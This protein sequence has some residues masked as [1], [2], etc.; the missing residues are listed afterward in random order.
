MRRPFRPRSIALAALCLGVLPACDGKPPAAKLSPSPSPAAAKNPA[1]TPISPP[2]ATPKPVVTPTASPAPSSPPVLVPA[3]A[4]PT[5]S[6]KPRPTPDSARAA[7]PRAPASNDWHVVSMEG[8]RYVPVADVAAFYRMGI[9]ASDARSFRL[10]GPNRVIVGRAGASEVLINGVKYVTCFPTRTRGSTVYLSA[11]D[12]TKI[13]EPIMRPGKIK[14]AQPIRAVVLDAGHGGHDSG[15]VGRY[16]REKDFTLDVVLRTRALLLKAG[17]QVKTTRVS[18]VFIPLED[19]A[20]Y[21]RGFP[22]A[23]FVSVHFNKSNASPT[24]T[25]IETYALAPRGVPSMDEGSLRYSDF[26]E[27]PGNVNDARN[28]AL[29]A[30]IHSMLMRNVPLPDRGIKRARFLVLKNNHVPAVLVEGG[31][32][33]NARDARYIASV[34]YRQRLAL[35]IAQAVTA[36]AR[37]VNGTGTPSAVVTVNPPEPGTTPAP[38][39]EDTFGPAAAGEGEKKAAPTATPWKVDRLGTEP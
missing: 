5:A 32:V 4:S 16:G 39:S 7:E 30:A 36:Y 22:G 12:V 8:R 26:R 18:D 28:V 37:T 31:F 14:G 27:N 2:P 19:R 29:A 15:A 35:S 21:G 3:K 9:A 23:V 33:D 6:P 38:L 20:A 11:M 34:D 10:T 17:F 13:V 1:P 25:G 24:G